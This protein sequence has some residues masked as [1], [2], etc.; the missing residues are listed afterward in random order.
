VFAGSAEA[1][2]ISGGDFF[3]DPENGLLNLSS[4]LVCGLLASS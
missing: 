4:R 1:A 3:L 2:V